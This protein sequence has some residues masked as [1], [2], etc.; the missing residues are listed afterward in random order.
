[1]TLTNWNLLLFDP[2]GC[3]N[4]VVPLEAFYV[5]LLNGVL[6]PYGVR[7][8]RSFVEFV[9]TSALIDYIEYPQHNK[10]HMHACLRN[11]KT[12]SSRS[13]QMNERSNQNKRRKTLSA[14]Y[15]F[16]FIS[17]SQNMLFNVPPLTIAEQKI[18]YARDF[19]INSFPCKLSSR[20]RPGEFTLNNWY[21]PPCSPPS[22]ID[23]ARSKKRRA[24]ERPRNTI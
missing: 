24:I 5:E 13:G 16:L 7:R 21:F 18:E 22:L 8:A 6:M 14:R 9:I 2:L 11:K 4:D 19:D 12:T 23:L 17:H 3:I 15:F 20:R 10:M 1:M